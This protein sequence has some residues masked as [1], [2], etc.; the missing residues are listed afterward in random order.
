MLTFI[1][2]VKQQMGRV[3]SK[4]TAST[5][6][7]DDDKPGTISSIAEKRRPF[8]L[9]LRAYAGGDALDSTNLAG[10]DLAKQTSV[11]LMP[12]L[13]PSADTTPRTLGAS[14]GKTDAELDHFGDGVEGEERILEEELAILYKLLDFDGSETSLNVT[15]CSDEELTKAACLAHSLLKLSGLLASRLK[16]RNDNSGSFR[17]LTATRTLQEAIK[18]IQK[19]GM[20]MA[21]FCRLDMILQSLTR[22]A[23]VPSSS[24]L[25]ARDAVR[26]PS[27]VNDLGEYLTSASDNLREASGNAVTAYT[28]SSLEQYI[29]HFLMRVV[30]L[31]AQGKGAISKAPLT[32]NGIESLDRSG[33]VLYRDLKGATSFDNSF[34]D[35]ELAAVAFER[36]A[37]FIAMMELEMEELVAYYTANRED[38]SEDDFILMFSMTG[39][40]RRG[41]VG[42]YHMLKRRLK[43]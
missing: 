18:T 41:D 26:I 6:L 43:Q 39:P 22:M 25:V 5:F 13:P 10:G 30:R 36:S 42:Q 16:I 11:G 2:R 27:S 34:W 19:S 29:P 40:R 37:S 24:T 1:S 31:V 8:A 9:L 33:S 15:V 12:L 21:K 3:C 17:A 7:D 4:K 38:F 32:M 23:K 20:K 35:V 14:G 28:F